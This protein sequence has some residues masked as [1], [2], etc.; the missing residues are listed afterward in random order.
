MCDL[1]PPRL[2]ELAQFYGQ[3]YVGPHVSRIQFVAW[4]AWYPQLE[5]D[6]NRENYGGRYT[7]HIQKPLLIYV[8]FLF[9]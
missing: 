8:H 3:H 6:S 2:L 1:T 9:V 5:A 7:V 4:L